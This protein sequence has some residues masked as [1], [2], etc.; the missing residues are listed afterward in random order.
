MLV[1]VLDEGK[2]KGRAARE[3]L[4]AHVRERSKSARKRFDGD[5][6]TRPC[7]GRKGEFVKMLIDA[8]ASLS[9]SLSLLVAE[10]KK[11]ENGRFQQQKN[12]NDF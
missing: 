12:A 2:K 8:A 10:K 5:S 11:T 4:Q 3:V 6:L 1:V 9:L 7:T